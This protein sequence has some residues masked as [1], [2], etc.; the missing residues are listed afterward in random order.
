[1]EKYEIIFFA[2][3]I[4]AYIICSITLKISI[5]AHLLFGAILAII[6]ILAVLLKFKQK[7]V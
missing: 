6:L 4:M 2:I 7:Y 1:M 3:A 5:Y